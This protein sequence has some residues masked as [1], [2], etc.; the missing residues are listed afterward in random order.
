MGS[1]GVPGQTGTL[2]PPLFNE[3]SEGDLK[4]SS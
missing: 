4:M 3:G 1:F 2:T